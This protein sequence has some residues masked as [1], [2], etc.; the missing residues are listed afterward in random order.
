VKRRDFLKFGAAAGVTAACAPLDGP[1]LSVTNAV[2]TPRPA[3][4]TGVA[5]RG[6]HRFGIWQK[7]DA[8]IYVPPT[9]RDDTPAPFLVLLH[10][11][12]GRASNFEANLPGRVDDK[13]IVVL[14]F[15]SSATTWDRFA[16]GGFGP[17]VERMNIALDYAFRTVSVDADHVGL[18]GFSDGASYALALGLSNGDLFKAL[19]AFSC[20]AGLQ[21]AATLRGNP[22]IFI[23]HGTTDPVIPISV[24]RDGVVPE[25]RDAG[26]SVTFRE[27]A[28]GHAIPTDVANEAFTWFT[29]LA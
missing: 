6:F 23:S 21:Y 27:F 4:F 5:P 16:L 20:G 7:D 13:G 24:S 26:Y 3:P 8:Y 28:G 2:V 11:A 19:I 9:Y 10:G 25:L 1:G 18:A 15:D 14:A 29:S 22:P 12:G 17:D